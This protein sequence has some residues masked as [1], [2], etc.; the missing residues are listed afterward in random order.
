[1]L[2]YQRVGNSV[3]F[4]AGYHRLSSNLLDT[5]TL[6]VVSV[7]YIL[8]HPHLPTLSLQPLKCQPFPVF[9][10]TL[11]FGEAP[12]KRVL[13]KYSKQEAAV[14][15]LE[16]ANS[17][18]ILRVRCSYKDVRDFWE[19]VTYYHFFWMGGGRGRLAIWFF[20][21]STSLPQARTSSSW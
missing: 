18:E 21:N 20:N 7:M 9:E 15:N 14:G 16:G 1:M 8:Y 2:V 17:C 3:S 4:G 19:G 6:V 13:V 11:G 10:S 12:P 5:V